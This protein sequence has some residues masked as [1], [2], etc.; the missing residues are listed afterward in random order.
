MTLPELLRLRAAAIHRYAAKPS[1]SVARE[2]ATLEFE[3]SRKRFA[4]A[5]DHDADHEHEIYG[6]GGEAGRRY[7]LSISSFRELERQLHKAERK[8][9]RMPQ[10]AFW[11]QA[12]REE[13]I[14]RL[15]TKLKILKAHVPTVNE[16][17]N[18]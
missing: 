4:F 18:F 12:C 14:Y 15:E 10:T 16:P 2:I 7:Q 8:A 5:Y 9:V 1:D 13:M 11:L 17:E 6:S 3:A